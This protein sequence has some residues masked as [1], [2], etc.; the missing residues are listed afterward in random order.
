VVRSEEVQEW[1]QLCVTQVSFDPSSVSVV[2]FSRI[3]E[4]LKTLLGESALQ[5]KHTDKSMY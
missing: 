3:G 1:L 2:A 4:F 5:I